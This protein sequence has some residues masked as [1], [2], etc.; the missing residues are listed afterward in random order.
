MG[1]RRNPNTVLPCRCHWHQF[2]DG[3]NRKKYVV[4]I[5][6]TCLNYWKWYHLNKLNVLIARHDWNGSDDDDGGDA[7]NWTVLRRTLVLNHATMVSI[8]VWFP[9]DLAAGQW[10]NFQCIDQHHWLRVW[11]ALQLHRPTLSHSPDQCFVSNWWCPPRAVV[12]YMILP[13]RST[14]KC[15]LCALWHRRLAHRLNTLLSTDCTDSHRFR[16]M[17]C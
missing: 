11:H 3:R 8:R 9:M 7:M 17:F 13:T 2:V 14:Y 12:A 1:Q 6:L 5:G 4:Q 15:T 16:D 10:T